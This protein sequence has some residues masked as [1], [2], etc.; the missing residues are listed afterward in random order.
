MFTLPYGTPRLCRPATLHYLGKKALGEQKARVLINGLLKISTIGVLSNRSFEDAL[1]SEI[2]GFEDAVI[3]SVAITEGVDYIA[4]RNLK[5]F[6]NRELMPKNRHF[7]LR[8]NKSL[9]G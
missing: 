7:L 8:T 1:E 3:E 6:R 2:K 5:D 4:T 9:Q